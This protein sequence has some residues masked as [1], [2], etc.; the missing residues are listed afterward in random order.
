MW[1]SHLNKNK[2]KTFKTCRKFQIN[3]QSERSISPPPQVPLQLGRGTEQVQ[4]LRVRRGLA[5]RYCSREDSS[6]S[7][8]QSAELG[9]RQFCNVATTYLGFCDALK[10]KKCSSL[11]IIKRWCDRRNLFCRKI[12]S[13][14]RVCSALL[15]MLCIVLLRISRQCDPDLSVD[16]LIRQNKSYVQNLHSDRTVEEF[17]RWSQNKPFSLSPFS[18]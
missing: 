12:V 15:Y 7:L 3:C 14:C 9:A 13:N 11:G 17:V 8:L 2:I 18:T 5:L 16:A 10:S 1:R 4:R 6:E